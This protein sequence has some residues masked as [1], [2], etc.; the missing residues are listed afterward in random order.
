MGLDMADLFPLRSPQ[1][2]NGDKRGRTVVMYD[3][4]DES[5]NLLYQVCRTDSKGFFQRRPDGNGGWIYNVGNS[6]KVAYRLP[7][8]LDADPSEPVFV[9]EGEKDVDNLTRLGLVAT[10]N[11]GGAGKW[12]R[13]YSEILRGRYAVVIPDNDAAGHRHAR[14]VAQCNQ[15]LAASTRILELPG[16]PPGGDVSDW[17]R[18][19]G[20]REELLRLIE[21]TP[22]WEPEVQ[23]EALPSIVVNDQPMRDVTAQAVGALKQANVPSRIFRRG[24]ELCRVQL[25]ENGCARI[26][27]LNEAALR[28]EMA[29]VADFEKRLYSGQLVHV[30][31]PSH[32][33]QDILAMPTLPFDSLDAVI[34]APVLRPDGSVLMK[35]GYDP[36]TRL[37][38]HPDPHL[39][40]PTIPETPTPEDVARARA[41]LE[42]LIE[43]F[44]F[45]DERSRANA[46]ALLISAAVRPAVLGPT[47]MGLLDAPKQGNGKTLLGEAMSMIMTGQAEVGGLATSE[48]ERRKL[49]TSLLA[50]GK[51]ICILDNLTGTLRSAALARVLTANVWT[52]RILGHSKTITLP[53][54]ATWIATANNVTLDGDLL[55]RCYWIRIDAK[56]AKPWTRKGFRHVNLIQWVAEH[57]GELLA[58]ILILARAWF[59]AGRPPAQVPQLGKFESW[60]EVVGGILAHAGVGGFLGNQAAMYE[61][62]D[63]S[64]GNWQGFLRAWQTR[65]G[66]NPVTVSELVGAMFQEGPENTGNELRKCLP[67]DL[68]D[69]LEYGADRQR[70]VAFSRKLGRALTQRKEV[71][72]GD[73][74]LRLTKAPR[75]S[76][77]G[78]NAWRVIVDGGSAEDAEVVVADRESHEGSS[79]RSFQDRREELPPLP[80]FR[81]TDPYDEA[82]R[83]AIQEEG[84][85]SEGDPGGKDS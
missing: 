48:E 79:I 65:Y 16:L 6:R 28:G 71:R 76:H 84:R 67:G 53:Q 23:A 82:E 37:Y 15:G 81:S 44:P 50:E 64:D 18:T 49:I 46:M 11:P 41:L 62:V 36:T 58:A 30:A 43:D 47:P 21:A 72:Y 27:P 33:V 3:Y 26:Q 13:G 31:P 78:A 54:R 29:R 9:V 42:E 34:S 17:I 73:D 24:S 10:T 22:V 25:D 35:S 4:R 20:T 74:G 77:R 45:V 38:Y 75:D 69:A 39:E 1:E 12:R 80:H 40:I 19:G 59:A 60:C 2:T 85:A 63:E 8:L 61:E 5:G 56:M 70:R 52:D 32:V 66:S 57:R 7:E 51:T 68:A 14:Q 55:R 83:K